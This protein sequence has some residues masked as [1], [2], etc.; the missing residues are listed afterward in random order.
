MSFGHI[1]RAD[2]RQM[3]RNNAK[4]PFAWD[5]EGRPRKP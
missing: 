5:G 3:E 2:R 4:L 1:S